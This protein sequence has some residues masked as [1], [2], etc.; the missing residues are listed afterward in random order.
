M[1]MYTSKDK[2]SSPCGEPCAAHQELFINMHPFVLYSFCTA[3]KII[4]IKYRFGCPLSLLEKEKGR[5][6]FPL[7]KRNLKQKESYN[8][9][10]TA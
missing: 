2:L 4:S 9:L 10:H 1:K 6:S 5:N 8:P 3:V 7:T